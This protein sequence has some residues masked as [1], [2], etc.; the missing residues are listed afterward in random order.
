MV[1]LEKKL[2]KP[3]VRMKAEVESTASSRMIDNE[4][5]QFSWKTIFS[6]ILELFFGFAQFIC[7]FFM[8]TLVNHTYTLIQ[9]AF[10][11]CGLFLFSA[12]V[13]ILFTI[14]STIRLVRNNE[15]KDNKKKKSR[16]QI[17]TIIRKMREQQCVISIL[18]IVSSGIYLLLIIQVIPSRWFV[19]LTHMCFDCIATAAVA[20]S[21]ARRASK[22]DQSPMKSP[23]EYFLGKTYE[24]TNNPGI[25]TNE[26]KAPVILAQKKNRLSAEDEVNDHSKEHF[27]TVPVHQHEE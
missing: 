13:S 1:R 9:I 6:F 27:I 7:F 18:A 8:G 16:R 12:G 3:V 11:F 5:K 21:F 15:Y 2:F 23:K 17:T 14:E 10:S 24:N 22:E 25:T 26:K 19:I 20:F 4:R